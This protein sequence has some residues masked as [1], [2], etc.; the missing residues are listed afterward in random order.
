[1]G[2][3]A[4]MRPAPAPVLS[5]GK[6]LDEWT[7]IGVKLE[8]LRPHIDM[9]ET[10]R[11]LAADLCHGTEH[12]T[13]SQ[14]RELQMFCLELREPELTAL[15]NRLWE[16]PCERAEDARSW[17]LGVR[18]QVHGRGARGYLRLGH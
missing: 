18:L 6:I 9:R 2:T 16:S 15:W 1:M 14:R 8:H 5:P 7:S 11:Q 17:L 3:K 12:V 4:K 13:T 10:M